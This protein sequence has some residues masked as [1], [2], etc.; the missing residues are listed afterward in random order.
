LGTIKI[1]ESAITSRM[2]PKNFKDYPEDAPLKKEQVTPGNGI[3][4]CEMHEQMGWGET[5]HEPK[6]PAKEGLIRK[7][8]KYLFG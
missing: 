3:I 5:H 8:L 1:Q 6:K 7:F 4:G 2:W